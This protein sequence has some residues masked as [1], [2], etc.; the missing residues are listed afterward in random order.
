VSLQ[1]L[2][3]SS[4]NFDCIIVI[5][6]L[7]LIKGVKLRMPSSQQLDGVMKLRPKVMLRYAG[8]SSVASTLY[9]DG[10]SNL[11]E[12]PGAQYKLLVTRN[13]FLHLLIRSVITTIS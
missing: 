9:K 12:V 10:K 5:F 6:V 13:S 4:D 7:T 2:I 8:L 11:A 1:L 3:L